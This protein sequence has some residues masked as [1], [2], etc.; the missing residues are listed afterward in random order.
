M[1]HSHSLPSYAVVS[2]GNG[3][4]PA[5]IIW[6]AAVRQRFQRDRLLK[7]PGSGRLRTSSG[8]KVIQGSKQRPKALWWRRWIPFFS[9]SRGRVAFSKEVT[10]AS[11]S[12]RLGGGAGLPCDGTVVS[13]GLGHFVGTSTEKLKPPAFGRNRRFVEDSIYVPG[14]ERIKRLR[15]SMGDAAF[16]RSWVDERRE[17]KLI[18]RSRKA[19]NVEDAQEKSFMPTS[20]ADAYTRAQCL[21]AEVHSACTSSARKCPPVEHLPVLNAAGQIEDFPGQIADTE[22]SALGGG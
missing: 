5:D 2:T 16:Y 1:G 6:K 10:V 15:K 17:A 3:A 21:A 12:R 13:L 19:S 20:L 9:G 11:F 7:V 4:V 22:C 18:L 14:G 8:D